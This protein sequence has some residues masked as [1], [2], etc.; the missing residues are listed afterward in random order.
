M[1]GAIVSARD[2]ERLLHRFQTSGALPLPTTV[3][4]WDGI[5]PGGT[6]SVVDLTGWPSRLDFAWVGD[7]LTP[8]Q[9]FLARG[10]VDFIQGDGWSPAMVQELR[11]YRYECF[12]IGEA[13]LHLWPT[14]A[15]PL[16]RPLLAIHERFVRPLLHPEAPMLDLGALLTQHGIPPRGVVHVGAHEG[17]EFAEYRRLGCCPIALIE[18]NPHV[19]ARLRDRLGEEPDV[20]LVEGAIAADWGEAT[21]HLTSWDQS[22][23]LLPL[24]QHREVYPDIAEVG[25]IQV[26]TRPLD[27]LFGRELPPA[28]AFNLLNIDVQ[29]AEGQVLRGARHLLTHT[30]A[31]QLEVNYAEMYTGCPLIDDL[32]HFLEPLGFERVAVTTPFHHTWGD[33]LYVRRETPLPAVSSEG[34]NR[35]QA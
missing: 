35:E 12:A 30:A 21:L 18:A 15:P 11:Q 14:P 27:S 2:S 7:T 23:S 10:R 32:D 13:E 26:A 20:F 31:I 5:P 24:A 16:S 34:E 25:Q 33:A 17:Q 19:F 29:G 22:S 6:T 4:W 3:F 9:G 1:V 8:V 28:A